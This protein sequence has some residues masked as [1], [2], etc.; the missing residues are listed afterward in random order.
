MIKQFTLV[1][2]MV[3][4]VAFPF[5]L[6]YLVGLRELC[7]V[8][9]DGREVCGPVELHRLDGV[10]VGRQ[11]PVHARAVRVVRAQV[12]EELMRHLGVRGGRGK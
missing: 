1:N 2:S 5:F 9:Y 11:Q 8:L 12:Q 7:D 4:E 6:P 3:N 10:R